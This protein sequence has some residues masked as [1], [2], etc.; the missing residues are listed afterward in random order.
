MTVLIPAYRSHLDRSIFAALFA[1]R[2]LLFNCTD[3]EMAPKKN[4]NDEAPSWLTPV[5]KRWDEY[6]ERFDKVFE[7]FVKMQESQAAILKRLDD[8]ESKLVSLEVCLV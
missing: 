8:L 6:F 1:L 4:S 5:L 7:V 2:I 3:H